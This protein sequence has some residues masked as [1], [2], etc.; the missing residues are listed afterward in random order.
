LAS[1]HQEGVGAF[2]IIIKGDFYG[3]SAL[4]MMKRPG[5]YDLSGGW[6]LL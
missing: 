1:L 6:Y 2:S 4:L 3:S 5:V